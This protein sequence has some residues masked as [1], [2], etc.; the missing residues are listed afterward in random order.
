MAFYPCVDNAKLT[1]LLDGSITSIYSSTPTLR[2][3]AFR[4]ASNLVNVDLPELTAVSNTAFYD[5]TNLE[6]LDFPKVSS[7]QVSAFG[8]TKLKTLILRRNSVV[9]LININSF[10][11][12][13]FGNTGTGGKLYV[14]QSLISAYQNNATWA[15]LLSQN[16]NNQIL[17][18]E[19][20]PYEI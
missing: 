1:E 12:T 5:C 20:S 13:P 11:Y 6:F 9:T 18:I 19:G 3:S 16:A 14:P 2:N 8:Y 7:I 15:S 4:G 17:A 10:I